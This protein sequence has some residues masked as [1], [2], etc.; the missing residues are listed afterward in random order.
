MKS[1]R[2]IN[3]VANL[4]TQLGLRKALVSAYQNQM[5]KQ[6]GYILVDVRTN[7]HEKLRIR[8]DIL[9]DHPIVYVPT[10]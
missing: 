8:S 1:P 4:G 5:K 2:I 3:Q 9:N 6:Y 10:L 7:T